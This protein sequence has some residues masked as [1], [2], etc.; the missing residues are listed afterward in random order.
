MEFLNELYKTVVI[1]LFLLILGLIFK[2]ATED[3]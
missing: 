2:A 3:K 1:V